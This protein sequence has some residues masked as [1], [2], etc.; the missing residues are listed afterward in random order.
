MTIRNILII[1]GGRSPEH[2]IS[3]LSAV[4]VAGNLD[5]DKFRPIG[6]YVDHFGTW[7]YVEN[8]VSGG[9]D[10]GRAT[11][12]ICTLI[13]VH[14]Q[15]FLFVLES[16]KRVLID[17]VFPLIHGPTGEDGVLQGMLETFCLPYVGSGVLSSAIGMDKVLSK[18]VF[19]QNNIPVV[20]FIFF[21]GR[22]ERH[23]TYGEVCKKLG[24]EI[25]CV[26]PANMG[27]SIGVCK[28]SSSKEYVQAVKNAMQY[29]S[30]VLVEKF[31][32]PARE[33][34]CAVLGNE[35]PITSCLGEVMVNEKYPIYSYE[36]KYCDP[37]GAALIVPAQ[38]DSMALESRIKEL[39][40]RA[41]KVA[42]CAGYAR[43][44]F[45]IDA[46]AIYINELNTVPG[47]TEISLYPKMW[48]ES[49]LGYRDLITRLID[50][51]FEVY[52]KRKRG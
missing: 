48:A 18:Q 14:N 10:L 19:L 23:P 34:E 7:H 43:V 8:F 27:S 44:D 47:F 16:Q 20:P 11:G 13:R 3:L 15:V 9:S 1:C 17:A 5:G 38:F 29:D 30:K 6:V 28:V 21:R 31:I 32:A 42:E 25:L 36:A 22:D 33:I 40:V 4:G 37:G 52:L 24:V 35:Q 2:E 46:E 12:Q 39:A 45:L 41:F 26:K 49:G 50:L 51:A